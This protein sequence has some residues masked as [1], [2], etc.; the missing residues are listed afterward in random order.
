VVTVLRAMTNA[1]TFHNIDQVTQTILLFVELM[2]A[3]VEPEKPLI[4]KRLLYRTTLD[5]L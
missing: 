5:T 4:T 3:R 2:V 1:D